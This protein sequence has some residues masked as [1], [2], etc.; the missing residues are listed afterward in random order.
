MDSVLISFYYL[1]SI[2]FNIWDIY[3]DYSVINWMLSITKKFFFLSRRAQNYCISQA[4]PDWEGLFPW[5]RCDNLLFS[6]SAVYATLLCPSPSPGVC[7]H[8]Y[9]LSWWCHPTTLSSVFPFSSCLQYFTASRSD[10]VSH[11]CLISLKFY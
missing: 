10:C 3:F 4:L 5:C 6:C 1:F 2:V 11:V 9:P 8:S 7:S